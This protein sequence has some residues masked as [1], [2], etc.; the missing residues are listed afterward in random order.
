[1]FILRFRSRIV[2]DFAPCFRILL[3]QK[4][5]VEQQAGGCAHIT[6]ELDKLRIGVASSY[7]PKE[8]LERMEAF[9]V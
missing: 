6:L 9:G 3:F 1:M 4:V 8:R 5:E 2:K 7:R